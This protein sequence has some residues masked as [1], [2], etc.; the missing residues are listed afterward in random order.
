MRKIIFIILFS[1]IIP[2]FAQAQST[3]QRRVSN[4]IIVKVISEH[5]MDD[6]ELARDI[7][8]LRDNDRFNRRLQ[9][10]LDQVQNTRTKNARNRELMRILERAGQ[11]IDRLLN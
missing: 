5:K 9:R 11:D 6:E 4:I 2:S 8:A 3:A 10:M 7:E 1:L